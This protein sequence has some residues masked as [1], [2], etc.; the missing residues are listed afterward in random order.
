M[1]PEIIWPW[2]T[3]S[4]HFQ[5]LVVFCHDNEMR[6]IVEKWQDFAWSLGQVVRWYLGAK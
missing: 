1:K 3:S 6:L 2:K 4:N 5:E